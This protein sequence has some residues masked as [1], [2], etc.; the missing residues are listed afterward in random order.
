MTT[1]TIED[2]DTNN[3]CRPAK[4]GEQIIY[5]A[6]GSSILI[7][8]PLRCAVLPH[9]TLGLDHNLAYISLVGGSCI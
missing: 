5:A 8:L 4:L 1:E 3:Y 7:D 6:L 2:S 9:D